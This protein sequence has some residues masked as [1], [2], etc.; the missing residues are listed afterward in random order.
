MAEL[1]NGFDN[2]DENANL[3]DLTGIQEAAEFQPI[4]T[5]IHL[6][7]LEVG[8]FDYI[9]TRGNKGFPITA[10]VV[11]PEFYGRITHDNLFITDSAAPRLVRALRRV[12][13]IEP[14]TLTTEAIQAALDGK[15]ARITVS[16]VS[17]TV[18]GSRTEIT[19]EQA[20][21]ARARWETVYGRSNITFAGY[22][23][24][25]PEEIAEYGQIPPRTVD[26]NQLNGTS[27]SK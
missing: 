20:K 19:E 16:H 21:E 7:R 14:T 1:D 4:P 3:I 24:P 2:E 26:P 18:K 12:G 8:E 9:G 27:S 5:G 13:G 23:S 17:W 25:L 10:T 22:D 6:C 11:T 15:L